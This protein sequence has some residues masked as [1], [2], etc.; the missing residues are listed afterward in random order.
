MLARWV[1]FG[2][3]VTMLRRLIILGVLAGPLHAADTVLPDKPVGV[4]LLRSA[5]VQG[6]IV[7]ASVLAPTL[8]LRPQRRIDR[9]P[10]TRWHHVNKGPTWS[11]AALSALSAHAEPL[12][13][14]VPKDVAD[15]CPGYASASLADRRAFWVGFLS[16]LAKH[17]STYRPEAV[18]GGGR[19]Y[20]LL[21]ILPATARGY[22][23]KARTGAALMNGA[24]NLSCG[25]RIM[26]RTVRR[27]GVIARGMRGVAADWGPFHSAAKRR[28]MATWLRRQ[29]YCKSVPFVRPVARPV[30][31]VS[32]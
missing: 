16:A 24:A 19:W 28:D 15:W 30:D 26:T 29:S 13:R 3:S 21:Q 31:L 9:L 2:H 22:G 25:L 5:T 4:A 14:T 18:G 7:T 11:R 12:A 17:E 23:C 20:G 10:A 8:S 32:N 27:D 1:A 6:N